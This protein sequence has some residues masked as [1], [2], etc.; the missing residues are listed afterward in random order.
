MASASG[1]TTPPPSEMGT[2]TEGERLVVGEEYWSE[3]ME[4]DDV[5]ALGEVVEQD[6][7]RVIVRLAE[8]GKQREVDLVR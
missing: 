2:L 3:D 7:C 8:G 5:W 1:T 6:E 4:G